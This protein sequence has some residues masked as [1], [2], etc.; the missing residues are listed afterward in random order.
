MRNREV[1]FACDRC[2]SPSVALPTALYDDSE[3]MCRACGKS[4]MTWKA[5]KAVCEK[6]RGVYLSHH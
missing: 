5:F 1:A 3:V 2:G 6:G 4:L